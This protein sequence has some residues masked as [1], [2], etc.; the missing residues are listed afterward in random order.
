MTRQLDY[1]AEL[2]AV[3]GKDG[4]EIKKTE[5]M[6]HIFGYEVINDFTARDLQRR[7][8]QRFICTSLDGFCPRHLLANN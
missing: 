1:E 2:G 5:P 4:W 6:N 7:H 8:R 3:I